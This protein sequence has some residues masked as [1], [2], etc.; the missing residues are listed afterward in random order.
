MSPPR[1]LWTEHGQI[2][3]TPGAYQPIVD[4]VRGQMEQHRWSEH[5]VFAV[6]LALVE[7]LVNAIKHGNRLDPSKKVD[8]KCMLADD[9]I[10]IE[11]A[12]QGGGFDPAAVP[13]PT[14]PEHLER[15]SGR[16]I[17]LIRNFMSGVTFNEQGNHLIM[18]KH[19]DNND[20][21]PRGDTPEPP[22]PG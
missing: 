2:S 6:Q 5:D 11:I 21:D 3:S 12:D 13:D 19:R 4:A 9:L 22:T 17:M 10:R 14:D 18:E 20:G 8:V 1:W 7:A 16:G 15:P